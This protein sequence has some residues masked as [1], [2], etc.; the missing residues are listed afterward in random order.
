M[1]SIN[2]GYSFNTRILNSVKAQ[3]IRVY[4]TAQNPFVLYSPYMK[5]GGVDPE[6]TGFGNTGVQD[7]GNLSKRALTIGLTAPPTRAFLFGVNV[8]F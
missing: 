3:F 8:G 7:P 6:A 5:E 4:V 2:L 1:R